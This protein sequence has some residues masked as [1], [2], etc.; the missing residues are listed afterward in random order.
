VNLR[1]RAAVVLAA[2]GLLWGCATTKPIEEAPQPALVGVPEDQW[3]ELVD[4]LDAASLME[5]CRHAL[6]YLETVPPDRSF[7]FGDETRTAAELA[8]GLRRMMEIVGETDDSADSEAAIRTD[9]VVLKST[10]RDGQGEVLIT[11]YYEPIMEATRTAR[12]P[13]EY[14]VYGVPEDL[15][16]V[17]LKA[18]DVAA[19]RSSLVGRVDEG[20]LVPYH[21]RAD[22]DFGPGLSASAQVIGYLDDP[23]DVFFLQVQG[24]GTLEFADGERVRA[25]YASGNGQ[26]YRSIGRLLL[27]EEVMTVNEMSMQAIKD[28]LHD[29]PDEVERV[30]S[31]NPSYVFFRPLPAEGGPLGCFGVPVTA[32]RSIATDRRLFQ[33]PTVALLKG[34]IPVADGRDESLSRLV[35]IEDTGGAITGP[36]RV[37]LFFGAGDEAG[38]LA[39]RTKHLGE[40]YILLPKR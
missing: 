40:L 3:P 18:F 36:G 6:G 16:T 17:D 31:H 1:R 39:G 38:E 5:A 34:R 27:D 14:P 30:L 8:A 23:I 33:A 19:D 20:R 2:V 21:D 29:H 10:G 28:Y 11:G 32:G 24:S 26:P 35:V 13:F 25:G 12:P 22:I 15:I 9:F 37:D 7:R 4:D